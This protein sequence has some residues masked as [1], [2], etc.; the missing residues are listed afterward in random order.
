MAKNVVVDIDLFNPRSIDLANRTLHEEIERFNQKV[1]EFIQRLAEIG[2]QAAQGAYGNGGA[3]IVT[4]E[5]LENGVAILAD[6]DAVVFL[7][8]GAGDTVNTA[9]RY[10]DVMPFEISSGSY[11]RQ[12]VDRWGRPGMYAQYGYWVFGGTRYTEIQPRN[13]MQHAYD[14]IM[15]RIRSAAQEVFGS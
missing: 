9:N 6:G 11:S 8:F 4:L 7:E 14:E 5:P 12:N 3:V 13:G 15:S 10:A 1:N 2:Q